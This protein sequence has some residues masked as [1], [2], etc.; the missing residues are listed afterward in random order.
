MEVQLDELMMNLFSLIADQVRNKQELFDDEGKI[1]QM[2]L[3]DGYHLHEADAALTLMQTLVKKQT[4]S[5]F[6][7]EQANFP[8]GMRTMNSEERRRFSADAFAF[9]LKLAHLGV[10]SE[11]QR[12]EILER[13]MTL[14]REKIELEHI[15]ALV[16]F[17]LF[18]H[19]HERED[20]AAT[21]RKTRNTAWN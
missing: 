4:E 13:A 8:A 5:F 16:A 12:E 3:N 20:S 17:Q 6:G 19:S 9:A 15:K 14:Y 11:D 10:L 1:M 18:A 21:P 7:P 2:L